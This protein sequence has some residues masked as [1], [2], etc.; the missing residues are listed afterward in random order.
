MQ[1]LDFFEET[2]ENSPYQTFQVFLIFIN[3]GLYLLV[4][5]LVV[6]I[7]R[8]FSFDACVLILIGMVAFIL[9]TLF[10]ASLIY[11]VLNFSLWILSK[12]LSLFRIHSLAKLLEQF[13]LKLDVLV[14]NIFV[15]LSFLAYYLI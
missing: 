12:V 13:K 11:F 15:S 8:P 6:L 10:S 4:P 1:P 3:L 2:V 5:I 7:E 14:I 9:L